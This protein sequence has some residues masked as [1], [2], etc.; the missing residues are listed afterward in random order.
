ML[1]S[2]EIC[3]TLIGL[4][5]AIENREDHLLQSVID[6]IAHEAVVIVVSQ[7]FDGLERLDLIHN[8]LLLFLI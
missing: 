3:P 4:F 7:V 8:L 5:V 6:F 2:E 1:K